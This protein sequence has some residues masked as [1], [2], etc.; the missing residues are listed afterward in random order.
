M[1]SRKLLLRFLKVQ[2]FKHHTSQEV[3]PSP[4]YR[5]PFVPIKNSLRNISNDLKEISNLISEIE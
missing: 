4:P 3:C 5:H 2:H 1:A